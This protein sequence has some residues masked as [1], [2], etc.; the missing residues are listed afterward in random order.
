MPYVF[1]SHSSQDRV[2]VE[3]E[4]ISPLRANGIDTWYSLDDIKSADE[5]ELKIKEG[6][7]NCDRF[8]VAM[9]PR[10][11][12]SQWVK[13]EVHWA[14]SKKKGQVFPVILET[15]E[16]GDL[17]LQLP[18]IQHIDLTENADQARAQLIE[19]L[20]RDVV[21]KLPAQRSYSSDRRVDR[22]VIAIVLLLL[23]MV[24]LYFSLLA[25]RQSHLSTSDST[26][27]AVPTNAAPSGN[28]SGTTSP[29]NS[30][31]QTNTGTTPPFRLLPRRERIKSSDAQGRNNNGESRNRD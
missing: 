10:A 21:P 2:A 24:I 28:A 25:P 19:E 27:N 12:A 5:W 31:Q 1:I 16:P 11:I 3:R 6:L 23:G 26:N 8:L 20:G 14:L 9:T 7:E 15:C 4:I 17:H 18:L 13:A 30:N 22:L 29:S